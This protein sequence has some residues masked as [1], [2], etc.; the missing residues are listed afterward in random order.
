MCVSLS[1]QEG[2]RQE[3]RA[4]QSHQKQKAR[5]SKSAAPRKD[6]PRAQEL[7]GKDPGGLNRAGPREFAEES[8]GLA[9][10]DTLPPLGSGWGQPHVACTLGRSAIGSF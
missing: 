10:T 6:S 5:W 1:R 9:L 4:A 2:S 3:R 7:S 8:G